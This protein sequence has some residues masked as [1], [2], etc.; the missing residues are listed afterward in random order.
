MASVSYQISNLLEKVS[1]G[2]AGRPL[3]HRV[4]AIQ[5]HLLL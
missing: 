2:D 1:F 5:Q 4:A 3:T